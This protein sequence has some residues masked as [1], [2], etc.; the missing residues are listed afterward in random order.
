MVIGAK[1]TPTRRPAKS[2]IV[3]AIFHEEA[4]WMPRPRSGVR[5]HPGNVVGFKMD[6]LGRH[7]FESDD[8]ME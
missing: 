6:P 1:L 4:P 3:G 5:G 7:A 2:S 8:L